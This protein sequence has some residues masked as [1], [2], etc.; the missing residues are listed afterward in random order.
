MKKLRLFSL[1]VACAISFPTLI[2]AS[3][4]YVS[5]TGKASW[6]QSTAITSPC[7]VAVAFA[8]AVAGDTTYF[9]AGTYR[10][11]K[12]NTGT[13]ANYTS[14][15]GYYNP[16]NSGNPGNPIVF[17]A[18]PGE[19][20]LFT[21][22]GGGTAD[23][24]S[25]S[26]NVYATIFGTKNH[27]YLTFDGFSLQSDTGKKMARMVIG[28]DHS[29]ATTWQGHVTVKN[30]LFNGG[31]I[32][33]NSDDNNEGLRIEGNNWITVSN[34]KFTQYNNSTQDHNTGGIKMYWDTSCTIDNCEFDSSTVGC[35]VKEANPKTTV[36]NCFFN[37]SYIDFFMG[38]GIPPSLTDSLIF[39]NN[40]VINSSY[41][42]FY[43]EG[44]GTDS[45]ATS[46][47]FQI[48]NN[49]FYGNYI[50]VHFG[51]VIPGHGPIFYNNIIYG[52]SN[53]TYNL[54][55]DDYSKGW[56]SHLKQLD[57]NQWGTPW[58]TIWIGENVR[59]LFYTSLASWKSCGKL[60][61]AYNADCGS[62][63]NPGCGDSASNPLFVNSS[64]KFNQFSDFALAPN[65]PCKGTG[66]DGANMGANTS[67]IVLF[68]HST[69]AINNESSTTCISPNGLNI[70]LSAE[71][72]STRKIE[73]SIHLKT[74]GN[75]RITVFDISG[76]EVWK[77]NANSNTLFQ[78]IIW[79]NER[80]A[81]GTYFV[82]LNQNNQ[83]KIQEFEIT[84]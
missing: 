77:Q 38:A 53:T 68:G 59:N 63:T 25:G 26:V 23:E 12:R 44:A 16:V 46:N 69:T 55:T 43:W 70:T 8:N 72:I 61:S 80:I 7:S 47:D 51:F 5:P 84:R 37:G 65:S 21:G 11:P 58:K 27:S 32:K 3:A 6:A 30:C 24:T 19:L 28:I 40:I 60:D 71:K 4:H 83:R 10:T 31:S 33:N 82:S 52:N 74:A 17:M 54:A 45:G 1:I 56:E 42:G 22:L 14:Y 29:D 2:A 39:K 57:H 49:T 35:Y 64:G 73:F 78:K 50:N 34:C 62:N 20:L 81:S 66:R 36:S 48:Y 79:N 18:Y 15:D 13:S 41:F 75:Y 67:S 9:R 76:R